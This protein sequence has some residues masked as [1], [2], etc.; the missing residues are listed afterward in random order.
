MKILK[1]TNI[2]KQIKTFNLEVLKQRNTEEI[3]RD[4]SNK[5]KKKIAIK[6]F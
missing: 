1:V 5:K 2:S 4:Y 3:A 6:E